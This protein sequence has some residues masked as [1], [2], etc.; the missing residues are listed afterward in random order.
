MAANYSS[1]AGILSAGACVLCLAARIFSFPARSVAPAR[2]ALALPPEVPVGV[3]SGRFGN[4]TTG[5]AAALAGAARPDSIH[6]DPPYAAGK[7]RCLRTP[8][9]EREQRMFNT[10]SKSR[11]CS[12]I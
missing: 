7:L 1:A 10:V 6:L 9:T 3:E 11:P 4:P 8:P 5:G 2:P 12:W